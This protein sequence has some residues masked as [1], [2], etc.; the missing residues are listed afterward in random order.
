MQAAID[1]APKTRVRIVQGTHKGKKGVIGD[2]RGT[3]RNAGKVQVT[4]VGR[5][6]ESYWINPNWLE[7]E[8]AGQPELESAT[9]TND[10]ERT[11]A[12]WKSPTEFAITLK[13]QQTVQVRFVP[14]LEGPMRMHQFDFRGSVS[15]TG[16]Q[17]HFVL[18]LEAESAWATPTDYAQ[19]YAELLAAQVEKGKRSPQKQNALTVLEQT[20][21]K[22]NSPSSSTLR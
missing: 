9:S 3:G 2:A 18:A 4:E 10:C 22:D 8:E 6:N 12:L 21:D 15:P 1:L 13:S 7:L 20:N 19:N 16:F 5:F 17:S 14:S 11:P